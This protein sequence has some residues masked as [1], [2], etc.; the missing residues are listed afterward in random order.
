MNYD[1]LE[2]FWGARPVL[3][4]IRKFARARRAGPW[5]VLGVVLARAA[6]ST[7]PNVMLPPTI[8]TYGSTNLFVALVGPSGGGKGAATGA[9]RDAVHFVRPSGATVDV[10]ELPLGS[11]EGIAR[12]FLPM[13]DGDDEIRRTRCVF[14]V[15]EVSTLGAL[16]ERKGSTLL[17]ELCKVY[18]GEPIGFANAQKETRT[19]VAAHTYR[20]CLVAGVQPLRAGALLDDQDGGTPQRF[21]FLPVSD[22]DAP[23]IAPAAPVPC[24]VTVPEYAADSVE[25]AL[26]QSVHD[27]IVAMRLKTLR[28]EVLDPLDAHRP[29]AQL[30]VAAA[31]AVLDGRQDKI[32]Q[33]DWKLAQI[34]VAVSDYTREQVRR[35]IEE[36]AKAAAR[37][38]SAAKAAEDGYL[39]D[40]ADERTA[41]RVRGSV[42]RR[43]QRHGPSTRRD[44]RNT[45]KSSVRDRLDA[46]LEDMVADGVLTFDGQTTYSLAE[47][48]SHV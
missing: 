4:H 24:M 26:P 38:R 37:A 42:Q 14:T 35:A 22:P 40:K 23:D 39:E 1:D 45:L 10:G 13:K 12:T 27:E 15:G 44:L 29:L 17:A 30:K 6:A 11:G 18:M 47:G 28:G 43:I 5:A 32:T 16:A 20:A 2:E 34:V 7:E 21:Q 46:V 36:S 41:G 31:L 25:F 48:D 9:A 33:Q 19:P 3:E 8:G